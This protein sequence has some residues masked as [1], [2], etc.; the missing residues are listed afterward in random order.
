MENENNINGNDNNKL[1]R[2][3]SILLKLFKNRPNH[4]AKYLIE[5]SAFTEEF[6]Y[7]IISSK[8]L[9]DMSPS[10]AY[11]YFIEESDSVPV[12]F[13]DFDEMENF[14]TGI[15]EDKSV[16]IDT[17]EI[18]KELNF[19]LEKYVNEENYEEAARIRD[20]MIKNDISITI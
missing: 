6:I 18:T 10:D 15:I 2:N 19:K 4:L 3:L 16:T 13:T 12:Y 5:N 11:N 17:S 20:Y 1:Y 7:N 9:N 14:Y 8:K